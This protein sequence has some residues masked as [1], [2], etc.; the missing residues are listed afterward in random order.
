MFSVAFVMIL[1]LWLKSEDAGRNTPSK[2]LICAL[3]A[4]GFNGSVRVSPVSPTM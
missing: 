2:I 1:V 4:G 3:G